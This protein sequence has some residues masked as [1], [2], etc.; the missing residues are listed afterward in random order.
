M[1]DPYADLGD[2]YAAETSP[3]RLGGLLAVVP[4]GQ[5][6]DEVEFYQPR[7]PEEDGHARRAR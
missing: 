5:T 4:A 7:S 3:E 2:V 1:H 6:L